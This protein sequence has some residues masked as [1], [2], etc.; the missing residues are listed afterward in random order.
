MSAQR[1]VLL[2]TI[3][4]EAA[5]RFDWIGQQYELSQEQVAIAAIAMLTG[6]LAERNPRAMQF[7]QMVHDQ[8]HRSMDV[9]LLTQYRGGKAG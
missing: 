6:M 2:L 8:E 7:M 1:G 3:P 4:A 9:Q 5:D